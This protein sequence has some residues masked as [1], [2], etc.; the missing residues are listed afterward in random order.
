MIDHMIL[1]SDNNAEQLLADHLAA[2][3]H[4]DVLN[5]LFGDLGI[6]VNTA[7]TDN[8]TVQTYSLF[9]RV[10]YNATYLDRNDSE[11]AL[12]LLSESE[13]SDGIR[14]GIPSNIAIAEKFGDARMADAAGTMVGAELQNCG[15]VYYPEHTYLLC[16]MTKGDTIPDLETAISG[17][18]KLI[19]RSVEARYPQS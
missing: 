19:Y 10:L 6:K 9:L 13:F 16:I 17:V 18:S 2:T 15:L 14:A 4:L 11:K 12:K 5:N 8:M 7:N 1:Y 3:D